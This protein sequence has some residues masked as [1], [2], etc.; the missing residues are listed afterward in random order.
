[1]RYWQ[2]L[3]SSNDLL[4]KGLHCL[5]RILGQNQKP[6]V[7]YKYTIWVEKASS[8]NSHAYLIHTAEHWNWELKSEMQTSDAVVGWEHPNKLI[9]NPTSAPCIISCVICICNKILCFSGI[10]SYGWCL[11]YYILYHG[12]DFSQKNWN[13]LKNHIT[14]FVVFIIFFCH[15]D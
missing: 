13:S 7:Q 6:S 2:H 8:L 1:M 10:A 11:L 4:A 5:R 15:S 12:N 9:T 3:F 14:P